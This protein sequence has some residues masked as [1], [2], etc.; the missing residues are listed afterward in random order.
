MAIKKIYLTNQVPADHLLGTF[1]DDS[2]YDILVDEDC[3][4]GDLL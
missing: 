3:D 2:H 1:L 4:T